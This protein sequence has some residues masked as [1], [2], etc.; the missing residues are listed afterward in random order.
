MVLMMWC[1]VSWW[2]VL[3]VDRCRVHWSWGGMFVDNFNDSDFLLRRWVMLM[4]D[5]C[6]VSGWVVL[7]VNRCRVHWSWGCM[8]VNHFHLEK[9]EINSLAL[10]YFSDLRSQYYLQW[11]GRVR[12]Q[13]QNRLVQVL[14]RQERVLSRLEQVLSRQEQELSKQ[15]PVLS[16][17]VQVQVLSILGQAPKAM[18]TE[19]PPAGS[20]RMVQ[21]VIHPNVPPKQG[22]HKPKRTR[23]SVSRERK[24]TKLTLW[25][26]I[27]HYSPTSDWFKS[28]NW[29]GVCSLHNS[30][31]IFLFTFMLMLF[32]AQI[33]IVW[34]FSTDSQLYLY[35]FVYRHLYNWHPKWNNIEFIHIK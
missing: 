35:G 3:V 6:R 15:V 24:K 25:T 18:A 30:H 33:K 20:S 4:V 14:S 21:I 16:I 2:V 27:Q 17:Q 8:F 26:N 22:S 32:D 7:M 1:R 19:R 9:N 29:F 23:M 28:M 5:R 13:E 10:S 11:V 31:N 12:L 34:C